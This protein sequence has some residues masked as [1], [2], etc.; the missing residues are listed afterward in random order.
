MLWLVI[1]IVGVVSLAGYLDYRDKKIK[2]IKTKINRVDESHSLMMG[3][4][5]YTNDG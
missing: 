3:D 4:N 2:N 5:Q 1:I